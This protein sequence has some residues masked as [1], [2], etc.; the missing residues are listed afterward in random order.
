VEPAAERVPVRPTDGRDLVALPKTDLHVHLEGS[1]RATT[2]AEMADANGRPLPEGAADG[3][4]S[5]VDFEDF[6][7]QWTASQ[8]CLTT[9][10]DLRRIAVEFVQDEAAQGAR[11]VEVHVSLPEHGV[12]LGAW[13]GSLEAVMDGLDDG[14]RA[15]GVEWAVIVDLVRALPF[16]A[17]RRAA[18]VAIRYAGRG[19]IGVGLGGPER[20][21]ARP[22]AELFGA[23]RAAGL[24]SI[25]HAG[26]AAGAAS[27][28]EALEVLGAER[29]GHGV[30]VLE[31][32]EL[33]A[34]IRARG[35][36]LD[37]CPT[38]NV[39]TGVVKIPDEHPLPRLLEAGLAVSLNSDD[40]AMF[41]SP[42]A[43]EYAVARATFG[44]SD[45][46]LASIARTGVEASFAG[47]A[48]KARMEQ[49]ITA[50]LAG[51]GPGA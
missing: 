29:L 37:V 45:D 25:P 5:F 47:E 30:R 17:S 1:I 8:A 36:T 31:D 23:A 7:A 22:Y 21:S 26:E 3:R 6:L 42:L 9:V 34:E 49:G 35:V 19:V 10:D 28:R 18:D 32:A 51:G 14:G 40:P 33:V 27:V 38:S 44:L 39:M 13:E 11:Y 2:L 24:H 15:N 41:D 20:V 50:W 12:R 43:G 4:W 16:E 48:T 46:V